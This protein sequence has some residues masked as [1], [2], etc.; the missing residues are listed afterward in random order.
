MRRKN[1]SLFDS[2]FAKGKEKR[3]Q[4]LW[5]DNRGYEI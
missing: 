1:N 2:I 3:D 5:W 4:I